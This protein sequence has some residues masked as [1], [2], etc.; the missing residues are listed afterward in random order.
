MIVV[1]GPDG[2]GKTTLIN[3]I[4][5]ATGLQ[6]AP[7][8]VSKDAEAMVD[9]KLW[10]ELNVAQGWQPLIFDRHR[11]FS[12]PIYGPI[13]RD[14]LEPGFSDLQWFGEMLATFYRCNPVIIYCLPPFDVVWANIQNDEDNRVVADFHTIKAIWGAYFNKAVTD[15]VHGADVWMHD[16]T[17]DPQPSADLMDHIKNRLNDYDFLEQFNVQ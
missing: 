13:L 16:Y 7:R 4:K 8:V 12:E 10:V 14:K 17:K 3:Q 1:E 5:T 6:V 2:A 15:H 9:L 11:L